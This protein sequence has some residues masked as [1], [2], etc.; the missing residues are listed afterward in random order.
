M[1]TKHLQPENIKSKA[2]PYMRE[3]YVFPIFPLQAFGIDVAAWGL[4]L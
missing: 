2:R 1:C 4:G 3:T